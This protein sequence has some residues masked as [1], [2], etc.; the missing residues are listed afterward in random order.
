MGRQ[1]TYVRRKR[2]VE[3]FNGELIDREAVREPCECEKQDYECDVGYERTEA[4]GCETAEDFDPNAPPEECPAG[5]YF[6]ISRG[7]RKIPDNSCEG[8]VSY[9][10]TL[11][12]CPGTSVWFSM[13][14]LLLVA[15]IAGVGFLWH[16][17]MLSGVFDI[18]RDL[19]DVVVEYAGQTLSR[20]V[21]I[22]GGGGG[23]Q[24]DFSRV[25]EDLIEDEEEDNGHEFAE[26]DTRLNFSEGEEDQPPLL[27]LQEGR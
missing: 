25:P 8:G 24:K 6:E 14:N 2:N 16:N 7:Y 19:K 5:Q 15:G 4:G 12:P 21:T 20:V 13:S 26:R 17:G 18:A 11:T 27:A 9:T 1:I 22:R 23:Y 10:G 3:C